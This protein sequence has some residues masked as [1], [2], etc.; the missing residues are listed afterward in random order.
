MKNNEIVQIVYCEHSGWKEMVYIQMYIDGTIVLRSRRGAEGMP[1]SVRTAEFSEEVKQLF[2]HCGSV[3]EENG[4]HFFRKN[5]ADCTRSL[6]FICESK[7]KRKEFH[8]NEKQ[9]D[10][11]SLLF[12]RF[13]SF[14]NQFIPDPGHSYADTDRPLSR[15]RPAP[16]LKLP[17]RQ[18]VDY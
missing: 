16:E 12:D 10:Q 18:S 11:F 5:E 7:H 2:L 14:G 9:N 17:K 6:L 1:V 8:S 3:F 15:H 13:S 4:I